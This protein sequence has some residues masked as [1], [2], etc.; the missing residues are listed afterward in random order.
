VE[1]FFLF[2]QDL[3]PYR[4]LRSRR[5]QNRRLLVEGILSPDPV[6]FFQRAAGWTKGDQGQQG[7]TPLAIPV[8]LGANDFVEP[9]VGGQVDL[10]AGI[11]AW[12]IGNHY[13]PVGIHRDW[14]WVQIQAWESSGQFLSS[15]LHPVRWIAMAPCHPQ[16]HPSIRSHE[17]EAEGVREILIF[18]DARFRRK[19]PQGD[20]EHLIL[21]GRVLLAPHK[22]LRVL[23]HRP[24]HSSVE[25]DDQ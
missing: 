23:S 25:R 17:G 4:T 22:G 8:R 20:A 21:I 12:R 16:D 2:L 10:K 14:L 1:D 9:A 24:A 13:S 11:H 5:S 7:F 15:L 19:G 3:N 6:K 18:H